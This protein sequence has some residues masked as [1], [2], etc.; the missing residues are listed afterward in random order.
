MTLRQRCPIAEPVERVQPMELPH[1]KGQPELFPRMSM[2]ARSTIHKLFVE[3]K[4]ITQ[5]D[6]DLCWQ[7][8]NMHLP[9]GRPIEPFIQMLADKSTL[10]SREILEAALGQVA[11]RVSASRQVRC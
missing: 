4:L 1:S 2:M 3:G 7:T 6:F 10:L 11:P 5:G 9:P 8:P